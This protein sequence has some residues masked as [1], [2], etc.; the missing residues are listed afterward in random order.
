M[1]GIIEYQLE[2]KKNQQSIKL[3]QHW[4]RWK[5][6]APGLSGLAAEMIQ[7]TEDIGTQWI[8]YLCN[9]IVKE[10]CTHRTGS[11]VWYYQFANG[12]GIQWSVDLIIK[13]LEHAMKV[14]ER[15]FK[16]RIWHQID[17]DDMQFGFT[18]VKGT[19]DAGDVKS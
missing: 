1:N 10:G 18:E 13:L 3:L 14:V 4:K 11:Q 6:K 16:H 12:M 17:I 19:T 2:L 8:L 15:I 9:S 7:A 5:D